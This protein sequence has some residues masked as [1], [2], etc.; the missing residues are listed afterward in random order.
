MGNLLSSLILE[1]K[2]TPAVNNTFWSIIG[3]WF[4]SAGAIL[5]DAIFNLLYILCRFALNVVDFMQLLVQKLAGV[6]AWLHLEKLDLENLQETDVVFR[7]LLSDTVQ[8]VFRSM[9]AIF[10]VLLIVFSIVAI[11][12]NEYSNATGGK[13]VEHRQT[14]ASAFKAVITVILVP[15][16]LIAGILA[17]NAVLAGLMK[18]FSI[19][20][21]LSLS[22]QVFMASA[23]DASDYRRYASNGTRMPVSN[24]VKYTS[25]SDG[26]E[27]YVDTQISVTN[28]KFYTSS[29][30]F[31]GYMFTFNGKDYFLWECDVEYEKDGIHKDYNYLKFILGAYIVEASASRTTLPYYSYYKNNYNSELQDDSVVISKAESVYTNHKQDY[32]MSNDGWIDGYVLNDLTEG[33]GTI[34]TAARNTWGYNQD[35][36][37]GVSGWAE[38]NDTLQII[39]GGAFTTALGGTR[40]A[41]VI[42]NSDNW[43]SLHDGG[44]DGYHPLSV[45][46]EVMADVID[47]A[48]GNN[49]KLYFVNS[50]NSMINYYFGSSDATQFDRG[51]IYVED[52]KEAGYLVEYKNYGRVAYPFS[53]AGAQSEVEGANYIVCFYDS[54][55][56][57]YVPIANGVKVYDEYGNSYTFKSGK[58]ADSYHGAVIARGI[59]KKTSTWVGFMPTYIAQTMILDNNGV[60]D[61]NDTDLVAA[62]A[63]NTGYYY[64]YLQKLS[65]QDGTD[66]FAADMISGNAI[67]SNGKF[68]YYASEEMT[69]EELASAIY[70]KFDGFE[71][72][73]GSLLVFDDTEYGGGHFEVND[74]FSLELS[75][76]ATDTEHYQKYTLNLKYTGQSEILVDVGTNII[77]YQFDFGAPSAFGYTSD[78]QFA[79][80]IKTQVF[81][82]DG[83]FVAYDHENESKPF[84]LYSIVENVV[85]D[86]ASLEALK[87]A[88]LQTIGNTEYVVYSEN[89]SSEDAGLTG[90]VTLV[91][92]EMASGDASSGYSYVAGAKKW[93]IT[94]SK[95]VASEMVDG[96]YVHQFSIAVASDDLHLDKFA[97]FNDITNIEYT[98]EN[99][100]SSEAV[101]A[102]NIKYYDSNIHYFSDDSH[103]DT[104]AHAYNATVKI[105]E[106]LKG[107]YKQ[108]GYT[109]E[110]LSASIVLTRAEITGYSSNFLMKVYKG[111]SS[112]PTEEFRVKVTLEMTDRIDTGKTIDDDT[113]EFALEVYER[114]ISVDYD[115]QNTYKLHSTATIEQDRTSFDDEMYSSLSSL[116]AIVLSDLEYQGSDVY[117]V[118]GT[119]IRARQF[120][121]VDDRDQNNKKTFVVN[122]FEVGEDHVDGGYVF[123]GYYKN[124]SE[125]Y[126]FTTINSGYS[127]AQTQSLF[128]KLSEVRVVK[129]ADYIASYH[130]D[131]EHKTTYYVLDLQNV[132]QM[133]IYMYKFDL[134]DGRGADLSGNF[135]VSITKYA[136]N[137]TGYDAVTDFAARDAERDIARTYIRAHVNISYEYL[138]TRKFADYYVSG[139]TGTATLYSV[140]LDTISGSH[141]SLYAT[142]INVAETPE[143][144]EQYF[145]KYLTLLSDGTIN[146]NTSN[147]ADASATAYSML[148]K[149]ARNPLT[150]I[151]C[152][153]DMQER[154]I[155]LDFRLHLYWQGLVPHFIF[156]FYIGSQIVKVNNNVSSTIVDRGATSTKI[157]RVNHSEVV[158]LRSGMLAID[159]NFL[160]NLAVDN[161]YILYAVNWLVMVIAVV[162][163]FS[164]LGKAVWGLIKRIYQ[165]TLLFLI[166][167][168]VAATIPLDNGERFGKWRKELIPE[169]LGA[170]GVCLGL[171]FFFI[172]LPVI[173]DASAI[174]TDADIST[175][176]LGML[177]YVVNADMLNLLCYILFLLVAL[178][179]LKTVPPLIATIVGG[180]DA[181]KEGENT[182]KDVVNTVTEAGNIISGKAAMDAM[183]KAGDIMLGE[184]GKD[185]KRHGG[186]IPGMEFGRAAKGTVDNWRKKWG[187]RKKQRQEQREEF[188]KNAQHDDANDKLNALLGAGKDADLGA[189]VE[190]R[191]GETQ[192]AQNEIEDNGHDVDARNKFLSDDEEKRM[193]AAEAMQEANNRAAGYSE[194]SR[195]A[196]AGLEENKDELSNEAEPLAEAQNDVANDI[197]TEMQEQAEKA[198]VADKAGEAVDPVAR[199]QIQELAAIMKQVNDSAA[200]KYHD[201]KGDE[202]K[203]E[204]AAKK[205]ERSRTG[206]AENE[207]NEALKD[208]DEQIA[209][210][211]AGKGS[212][213]HVSAQDIDNYNKQHEKDKD[214]IRMLQ[215]GDKGYYSK[216]QRNLRARL[217][218]EKEIKELQNIAN[219]KKQIFED[220]KNGI[221]RGKRGGFVRTFGSGR[222]TTEQRIKDAEQLEK[223][224]ERKKETDAAVRAL[225]ERDFANPNA[226]FEELSKDERLKA[227]ADKIKQRFV[228][229]EL[230]KASFAMANGGLSPAQAKKDAEAAFKSLDNNTKVEMLEKAIDKDSKAAN[231]AYDKALARAADERS[232]LAH[233]VGKFGRFAASKGSAA[234][235]YLSKEGKLERKHAKSVESEKL[236]RDTFREEFGKSQALKGA[237]NEARAELA[238]ESKKNSYIGMLNQELN[239]VKLKTMSSEKKAKIAS[240]IEEGIKDG[241]L[242]DSPIAEKYTKYNGN[243]DKVVKDL[244]RNVYSNKGTMYAVKGKNGSVLL[245][246]NNKAES[247]AIKKVEAAEKALEDHRNGALKEARTAYNKAYAAR[248]N[249]YQAIKVNS[250]DAGAGKKRAKRVLKADIAESAGKVKKAERIQGRVERADTKAAKKAVKTTQKA[251]ERANKEA[252]KAAKATEK[253]RS[254]DLKKVENGYAV[255][256]AQARK[257]N[258]RTQR[259]MNTLGK[260][261][262]AKAQR[263]TEQA[264][265]KKYRS[266]ISKIYNGLEKDVRARVDREMHRERQ[267]AGR[268]RVDPTMFEKAV[269]QELE[270]QLRELN[271]KASS[272]VD[273]KLNAEL[274]RVKAQLAKLTAAN[275]TYSR[276]IKSLSESNKSL[277][278]KV[279]ANKGGGAIASQINKKSSFGDNASGK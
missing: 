210:A 203:A 232:G 179:L 186:L 99:I 167:P 231:K 104:T 264:L 194:L 50:N 91:V 141:Y 162:I 273:S 199:E 275:S 225:A 40:V 60:S 82:H 110:L 153:D 257:N 237:V 31:Y 78:L 139:S 253:Q 246:D 144:C 118:N 148:S 68:T 138:P 136:Y 248:K 226:T 270:K 262:A 277:A 69:R 33:A 56:G 6:D 97:E 278:R 238:A 150:V 271:K 244:E 85:T 108:S 133:N 255:A 44:I 168:A 22:G 12:K 274:N 73:G 240:I 125:H 212:R 128:Y 5:R 151:F 234:A 204:A 263:E 66:Y 37:S 102:H 156:R 175:K 79:D 47:F 254:R 239:G 121:Y 36:T 147:T 165:I 192:V 230:S 8:T 30:P 20:S 143:Q 184:K 182:K 39:S 260:A 189:E 170:Y 233:Q 34:L 206:K 11:L 185:G 164:V 250:M 196:L 279:K 106:Y 114:I 159:Y 29:N 217:G 70:Q 190:P 223:A 202:E 130:N 213:A 176:T 252:E 67:Y 122:A 38:N 157:Q 243:M 134:A 172:I 84:T 145:W 171:N 109:A 177:G 42:K 218:Q 107:K 158:S 119:A 126:V 7:F 100:G 88:V 3:N 59:F 46:Y 131:A 178:T 269:K 80:C 193:T 83:Y 45:E 72:Y 261:A 120:T 95:D 24:F 245:R 87:A 71:L 256:N 209:D 272:G 2:I 188:N 103:F 276:R 216:E 229:K 155:N 64:N 93:T 208:L 137:G 258:E 111:E 53:P 105:G 123:A 163:V 215:K 224:T 18:A 180:K 61:F 17:S 152:R 211:R 169:V 142:N 54:Q 266:D 267:T 13:P 74:Q 112:S 198:N 191:Q 35:L 129:V 221:Y 149:F 236:A 140:S 207:Y 101:A 235:Q 242:N 9:I 228:D 92:Y 94:I 16:V 25:H 62:N 116:P 75:Y 249:A 181:I 1:T 49:V 63:Q 220:A 124:D 81:G 205:Y 195:E 52:G 77:A 58:Y 173:R 268:K 214:F 132:S 10:L 222:K 65:N 86:V 154:W 15:V 160:G 55:A 48:L 19:N 4:V 251:A 51:T 14:W 241:A 135:D 247:A 174:F 41:N 43:A 98:T 127:V 200:G 23:Y 161:F 26:K 32:K 183:H 166:M 96:V 21:S 265:N 117:Y 219:E 89:H 115:V 90:S 57:V 113:S 27:Y 197:K 76:G 201:Y 28:P 187:E 259:A 227:Q 146:Y